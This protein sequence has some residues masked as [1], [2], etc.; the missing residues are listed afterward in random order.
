MVPLYTTLSSFKCHFYK[1][2]HTAYIGR[3]NTAAVKKEKKV[4]IEAEEEEECI[5]P[6]LERTQAV[7]LS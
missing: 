6:K 4:S 2:A 1:A 3:K 7:T 5:V